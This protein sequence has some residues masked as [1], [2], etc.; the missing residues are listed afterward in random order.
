ML[1][2]ELINRKV[3]IGVSDPWDFY[4]EHGDGPF[5]ATVVAVSDEAI[6][7]R[8]LKQM[9][10][11]GVE[12]LHLVALPRHVGMGLTQMTNAVAV[13]VNLT[14]VPISTS[15]SE[16]DAYFNTAAAWRRWHL[17]GGLRCDYP[18]N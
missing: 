9:T 2:K 5:L 18:E 13:P 10:Y 12:F 11:G 1:L 16:P 6:L 3:V 17:I 7:L 15:G 8:L 14:P 4:T